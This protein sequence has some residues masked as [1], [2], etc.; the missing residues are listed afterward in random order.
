M[1]N[2]ERHIVATEDI[3]IGKT[4]L[5][6]EPFFMHFHLNDR[7]WC[8]TC[9][10]AMQN[11]IQCPNCV[12]AMFCDEKCMKTNKIHE[13]SCG[14]EPL[15]F[16]IQFVVESILTAFNAFPSVEH[17]MEFVEQKLATPVL[18]IPESFS[19][20]QRNYGMLLP[21]N[22]SVIFEDSKIVSSLFLAYDRILKMPICSAQFNTTKKQRFLIH[23]LWQH[24]LISQTILIKNF[25]N[26]NVQLVGN[27]LSLLNHS[28]APNL[29]YRF[30]ENKI[31]C[32]TIN[33]VK[34]GQQLFIM[35]DESLWNP[36]IPTMNRQGYLKRKYNFICK[37]PKCVSKCEDN[38]GMMQA[39]PIFWFVQSELN[40]I[41]FA[42]KEKRSIVKDKCCEFLKKIR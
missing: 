36:E 15:D 40:T 24:F 21:H 38:R 31:V 37:C 13:I 7:T 9:L 19:D 33:R 28:C 23:L 1:K 18:K 34:K 30:L 6:E 20:V 17:L 8:L 5:V 16:D 42:S 22:V 11:F 35:Y 41:Q 12:K 4:V 32:T 27:I 39:V 3:E 10:K 29:H 14:M 26:T 25:N 2:S